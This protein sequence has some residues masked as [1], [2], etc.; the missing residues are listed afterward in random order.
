MTQI[1]V[2]TSADTPLDRWD[3][4]KVVAL[5]LMFVDHAGA[6]FYVDTQWLRA[7]GRGAAPIFLFL[8]GYAASLRIRR[9]LPALA[10][11][12]TA[13]DFLLV[14][15]LRVQ[16]I[17]VTIILCRLLL[18]FAERKTGFIQRPYEWFAG[19]V[20]LIITLFVTQY[21]SMGFLLAL[22]GYVRRRR[23]RYPDAYSRRLFEL[24]LLIYGAVEGFLAGFDEWEF[25]LTGLVLAL[26]YCLLL[27]LEARK[28]PAFAL[29]RPLRCLLKLASYHSAYIYAF[30]LIAL[31]WLTG[32]PF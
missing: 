5:L 9:E 24:S 31:E 29:P 21:G 2:R 13:S 14:G 8:A 3:L 12:M 32:I 10:L 27:N 19:A 11:L 15:H 1:S 23:E 20:A 6:F 22:A 17:L 25:A 4:V 16:N 28:P 30:H 26:D 7:I 18:R